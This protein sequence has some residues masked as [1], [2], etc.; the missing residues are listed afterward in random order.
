MI[1]G[2]GSSCENQE[3]CP[4]RNEERDRRTCIFSEHIIVSTKSPMMNI[5][6]L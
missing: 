6:V 5:L 3:V 4:W 1:L 2:N